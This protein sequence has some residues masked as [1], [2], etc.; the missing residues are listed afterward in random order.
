M[1]RSPAS[2]P[3]P[4]RISSRL[5]PFSCI[6]QLAC[7]GKVE[8]MLDCVR[9]VLTRLPMV[10]SRRRLPAGKPF[11]ILPGGRTCL[12]RTR[13]SIINEVGVNL[14]LSFHHLLV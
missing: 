3:G 10:E 9:I 6:R 7:P 11:A 13:F 4:N 14:E 1:P 8:E 2:H 5:D 12:V